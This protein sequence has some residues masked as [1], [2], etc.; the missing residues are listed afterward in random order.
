MRCP[1]PGWLVIE[2]SVSWSGNSNS[3]GLLCLG[4]GYQSKTARIQRRAARIMKRRYAFHTQ[5]ERPTKITRGG[6]L[7]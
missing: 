1:G 4:Y 5:A 7:S 6:T 2:R 3:D